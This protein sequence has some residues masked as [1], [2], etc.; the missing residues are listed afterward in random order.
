MDSLKDELL[1]DE[2]E[3]TEAP[4]WIPEDLR[5]E[6]ALR[7]FNDPDSVLKSIKIPSEDT[8]DE[9]KDAFFTKLGMPT[10]SDEYEVAEDIPEDVALDEVAEK[11]FREFAR[12]QRFT[13]AQFKDTHKYYINILSGAQKI[14][15]ENQ[16]KE[17]EE[18]KTSSIE[19]L[20]KE[21]GSNYDK[22][23]EISR[24]G[25]QTAIGKRLA[26]LLGE[27][28]VKGISLGNYPET[29][30]I[31]YDLGKED[32]ED[33]FVQGDITPEKEEK[34]LQELMYDNPRSSG[35]FSHLG[36]SQG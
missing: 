19:E 21:W 8:P 22:N 18:L 9:D 13:K 27:A 3:D 14:A 16:V 7:K 6:K 31:F 10:T 5:E 29:I 32:A 15:E 25:I 35:M 30:Q 20:K 33:V 12:S 4:E 11:S 23:V 2:T 28:T 17:I 26:P 1:V 24:R 34:P 36:E